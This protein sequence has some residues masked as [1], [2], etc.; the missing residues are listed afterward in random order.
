[1]KPVLRGA[2]ANLVINP[3]IRP[4]G[5]RG[6]TTTALWDASTSVLVFSGSGTGTSEGHLHQ[7]PRDPGE[8]GSDQNS[9]QVH[10]CQP[11]GSSPGTGA[12]YVTKRVLT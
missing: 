6:L 12:M 2:C 7:P 3:A 11:R 5:W 1:M 10:L 9:P 8:Y 4:G